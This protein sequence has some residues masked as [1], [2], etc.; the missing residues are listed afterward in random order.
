MFMAF[1]TKGRGFLTFDDV[2]QASPLAA[3]AGAS[4]HGAL[5][6][7]ASLQGFREVM[8]HVSDSLAR[9]AFDAADLRRTGKASRRRRAR[10]QRARRHA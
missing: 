5:T 7:H 1:D 10:R 9:E 2:F 6:P 3:C 8:P 4:P